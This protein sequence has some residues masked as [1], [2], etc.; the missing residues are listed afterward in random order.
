VRKESFRREKYS[1]ERA[2]TSPQVERGQFALSR[3]RPQKEAKNADAES[4][5]RRIMPIFAKKC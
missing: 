5:F 3:Q 1:Q 4:L 2:V